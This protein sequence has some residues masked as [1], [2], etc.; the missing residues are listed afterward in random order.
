MFTRFTNIYPKKSLS[1]VG[2]Y[3]IHGACMSI[4]VVIVI[5]VI[6]FV[7]VLYIS[8]CKYNLYIN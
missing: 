1:F 3:T 5:V 6:I 4:W 2:K 8:I 7:I